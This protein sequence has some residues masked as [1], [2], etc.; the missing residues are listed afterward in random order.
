MVGGALGQIV[1]TGEFGLLEK[2]LVNIAD[3]PEPVENT[4][5]NV[6][7]NG[8]IA[9]G[10][11]DFTV[12]NYST[13]KYRLT[14]T[15]AASGTFQQSVIANVTGVAN[16]FTPPYGIYINNVNAN[17]VDVQ[18]ITGTNALTNLPFTFQRTK[19]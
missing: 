15:S 9:G 11:G 8:A 1:V 2:S 16:N 3:I 7:I 5:G 18:I 19:N 14:F 10:S 4:F 6:S 13:G 12:S 17:I